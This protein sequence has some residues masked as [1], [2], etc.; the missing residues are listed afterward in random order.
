VSALQSNSTGLFNTAVGV[1]GQASNTAG[2]AEYFNGSGSAVH[3]TTGTNNIAVGVN[4]AYNP[5]A[6]SKTTSRSAMLALLPTQLPIRVGTQGTQTKTFIAGV[7]GS[8][9]TGSDVVVQ[10]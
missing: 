1:N 8:A 9:V 10:R 2:T 7:S 6:G 5:T 4:A 3:D